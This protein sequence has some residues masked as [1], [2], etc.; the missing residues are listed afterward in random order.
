MQDTKDMLRDVAG[1]QVKLAEQYL[2]ARKAAGEAKISLDLILTSK[3]KEIRKNKPNAGYEM[4]ILMLCEDSFEARDYYES[5]VINEARYK[6]LER[7]LDAHASRIMLEMA[8]LKREAQ[9]E[10]K[11]Y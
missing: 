7:L 11:G 4:A 8:I 10:M 2:E 5:L 3:L 9:G 1:K 6:G